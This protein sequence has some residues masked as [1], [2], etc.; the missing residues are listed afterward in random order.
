MVGVRVPITT[1][2]DSDMI[3]QT[4]YIGTGAKNAMYTLRCRRDVLGQSTHMFEFM[5]DFYVCTLAAEES[6]AAEKAQTYVDAMRDRIGESDDF[7][8]LF[9]SVPDREAYKRIGKLSVQDTH[10]VHMIESGVL[11][12]G[13]HKGLRIEDA[14]DSYV[15]FFADKAKEKQDSYVLDVLA[16]ACMGSA[17][18]RGLIAK[19]AKAREERAAVDCLSNFIG[20]IGE[21]REFTG[22]VVTAFR[23]G[24]D[25]CAYWINKVRCGNNI[26]TYIGGKAL[27]ELGATITFRG[28]IQKHDEYQGIK[29]TRINRPA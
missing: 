8:I 5:P 18:E 23:K 4:Y 20:T 27:G 1:S 11:P 17:L 26:V 13:K 25:G 3:Q 10:A 9:D 19:R 21:R 2:K 22:E 29:S 6:R 14:P 15:L 12:F 7:K 28:T 24:E 16:S